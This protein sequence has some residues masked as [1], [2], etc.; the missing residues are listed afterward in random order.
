M[1]NLFILLDNLKQKGRLTD[2]QYKDMYE[3]LN[4]M[5][6]GN[7]FF[8]FLNTDYENHYVYFLIYKVSLLG[9]PRLV[10]VDFVAE[11]LGYLHKQRKCN[12]SKSDSKSDEC[13]EPKNY[14]SPVYNVEALSLQKIIFSS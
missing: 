11:I 4:D 9:L 10:G 12:R 6:E 2:K 13:L 14:K 8:H 7:R 3:S 5:K 1:D